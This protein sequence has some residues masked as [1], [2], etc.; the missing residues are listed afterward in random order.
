MDEDT[1][2]E[3][4][5][6]FGRSLLDE[7]LAEPPES[8]SLSDSFD[9]QRLN[10]LTL[11]DSLQS[12][13]SASE[14]KSIMRSVRL[15]LNELELQDRGPT[16][17]VGATPTFCDVYRVVTF[18][19]LAVQRGTDP[20]TEQR[21]QRRPLAARDDAA[22]NELVHFVRAEFHIARTSPTAVL[23]ELKTKRA[24]ENRGHSSDACGQ[25]ENLWVDNELLRR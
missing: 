24:A 3:T 22:L 19:L 10:L 20:N 2:S 8:S 23:Q 13:L 14:A 9:V 7:Q 4:F 18:A 15:V 16:A 25:T 12:S 1:A 21:T 5:I 17:A 11:L 6:Q